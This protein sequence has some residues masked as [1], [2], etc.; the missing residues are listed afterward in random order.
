LE[1]KL[2]KKRRNNGNKKRRTVETYYSEE[3]EVPVDSSHLPTPTS[4]LRKNKSRRNLPLE[5]TRP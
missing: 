5:Q 2:T 3:E 1:T 4:P